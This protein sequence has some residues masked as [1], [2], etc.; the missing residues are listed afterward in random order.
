MKIDDN[1]KINSS[2]KFDIGIESAL[3]QAELSVAWPT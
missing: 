1:S 3:E 2:E